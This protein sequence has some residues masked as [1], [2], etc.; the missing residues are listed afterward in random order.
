MTDYAE[1]RKQYVAEIRRSFD[2][3]KT[4]EPE[5]QAVPES[6]G[7]RFRFVLAVCLFLLFFCWYDSGNAFYGIT[8]GKVI[9]R[10]EEKRYDDFLQRYLTEQTL[11]VPDHDETGF[12]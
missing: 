2:G 6:F 11:G 12:I 5:E 8:A 3:E 4:E 10:I 9:D 1:R 7:A